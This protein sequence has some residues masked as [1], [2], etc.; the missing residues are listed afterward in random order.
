MDQG[1]PQQ[2]VMPVRHRA[3]IRVLVVALLFIIVLTIIA[4]YVGNQIALENKLGPVDI[5]V[6]TQQVEGWLDLSLSP[7]SPS[8]QESL[9]VFP[10]ISN[11]ATTKLAYVQVDQLIGEKKAFTQQYRYSPDNK[12]VVFIGQ[13]LAVGSTT[14]LRAAQVYRADVSA[15][16]DTP[17]LITSLRAGK[18]ISGD[19]DFKRAPV[20][21]NTGN[22]LYMSI[23]PDI[24]FSDSPNAWNIAYAPLNGST[25]KLTNGA[26]PQWV[27]A[28]RFIF[29]K[30][31]GLYLYDMD[32]EESKKISEA[33]NAITT[34]SMIDLSDDKSLIA[35]SMPDI[36]IITIL[37]ISD[38]NTP[39]VMNHGIISVVGTWPVIAPDSS[40]L[41][42]ITSDPTPGSQSGLHVA[43]YSLETFQSIPAKI[44]LLDSD[45]ARTA[46]TDWTF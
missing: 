2:Q 5:D 30:S 17:T 26:Y 44:S 35:W 45:P 11:V 10:F 34:N 21:S 13:G 41:A 32:T 28:H 16:K 3:P 40:A 23:S 37:S 38:W 42:I 14:T 19:T 1:L 20:V 27:D 6:S 8:P 4:L 24:A 46:L 12:W 43:L 9:G 39:I 36:G 31:D 33:V 22:I 25:K 18:V 15:G 7:P 29:L